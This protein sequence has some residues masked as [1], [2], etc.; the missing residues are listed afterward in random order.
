[1]QTMALLYIIVNVS[2]LIVVDT[3]TIVLNHHMPINYDNANYVIIISI[4]SYIIKY[5]VKGVNL[6]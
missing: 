1:M 2:R 5:S 6:L 3:P 4:L